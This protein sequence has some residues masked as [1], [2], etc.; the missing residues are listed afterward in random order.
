MTIRSN[1]DDR[2]M[3]GSVPNHKK[4]NDAFPI[5]KIDENGEHYAWH[6]ST[7]TLHKLKDKSYGTVLW[8]NIRKRKLRRSI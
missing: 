1:Y 5:I 2:I 8:N 6:V 4:I 3:M 7:D